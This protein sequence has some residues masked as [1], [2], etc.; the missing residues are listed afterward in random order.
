MGGESGTLKNATWSIP[1]RHTSSEH[2]SGYEARDKEL[3]AERV[4]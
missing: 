4:I 3:V 1:F 2:N